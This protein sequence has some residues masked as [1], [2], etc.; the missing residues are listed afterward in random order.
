MSS[1]KAEDC[2]TIKLLTNLDCRIRR[3]KIGK[4][5]ENPKRNILF[6]EMKFKQYSSWPLTQRVTVG[7][8]YLCVTSD[9]SSVEGLWGMH[10]GSMHVASKHIISY[11]THWLETV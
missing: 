3:V 10:T 4:K 8:N 2:R 11:N 5:T 1:Q 9:I 7:M 6:I